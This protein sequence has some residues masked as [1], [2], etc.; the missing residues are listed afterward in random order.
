MIGARIFCQE[1]SVNHQVYCSWGSTCLLLMSARAS[2]ASCCSSN[3]GRSYSKTANA[4]VT[5]LDLGGLVWNLMVAVKPVIG[6]STH[7]SFSKY[8]L[9]HSIITFVQSNWYRVVSQDLQQFQGECEVEG[10]FLFGTQKSSNLTWQ[11]SP[12]LGQTVESLYSLNVGQ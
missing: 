7:S 3:S 1:Y 10:I 8:V 11:Q 4:L 6:F 5:S 12:A 9:H 2:Q